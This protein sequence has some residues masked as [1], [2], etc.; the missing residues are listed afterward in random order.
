MGFVKKK[1]QKKWSEAGG[2]RDF[3]VGYFGGLVSLNGR[4]GEGGGEG[5][6][7]CLPAGGGSITFEQPHPF[8]FWVVDFLLILT[9]VLSSSSGEIKTV[10][11]STNMILLITDE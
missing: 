5:F 10:N 2:R 6:K 11:V 7:S 9:G 8:S 3:N 1:Q 4:K